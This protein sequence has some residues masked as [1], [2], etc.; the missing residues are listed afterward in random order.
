VEDFCSD[1]LKTL[2]HPEIDLVYEQLRAACADPALNAADQKL[3]LDNI[4]AVTIEL[5][6]IAIIKKCGL[7]ISTDARVFIADCLNERG[8]SHIDS[9]SSDSLTSIYNQAFGRIGQDGVA[10]IVAAFAQQVTDLQMRP[11]TAQRFYVEFSNTLK[12][13]FDKL[14]TV[15]LVAMR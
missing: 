3:Y 2:F 1:Y 5:M 6:N 4:R 15:K 12:G 8:L 11:E 9:L 14:K 10:T 7:D 13:F